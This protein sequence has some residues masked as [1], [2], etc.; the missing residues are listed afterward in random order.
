[1]L[2]TAITQDELGQSIVRLMFTAAGESS[3]LN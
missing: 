1:M 2:L 3:A